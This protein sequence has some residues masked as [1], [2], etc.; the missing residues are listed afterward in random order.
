MRRKF[1]EIALHTRCNFLES[2]VEKGLTGRMID[3]MFN[4][5]ARSKC[6]AFLNVFI[7]LIFD[8]LEKIIERVTYFNSKLSGRD[9]A[10]HV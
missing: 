6:N 2:F 3:V 9:V 7:S 5:R 4:A 1:K 8:D 10:V